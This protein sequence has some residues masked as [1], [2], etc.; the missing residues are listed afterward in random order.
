ML[1]ACL[2]GV[3]G[4]FLPI[5]CIRGL[6]GFRGEGLRRWVFSFRFRNVLHFGSL[7]FLVITTT[8]RTCLGAV[9]TRISQ[10]KAVA[11]HVEP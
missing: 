5:R 9:S 6:T 10:L 4:C 11:E 7:E 8:T 2:V 1:Q 3:F